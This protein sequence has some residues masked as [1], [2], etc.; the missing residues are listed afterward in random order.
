M[1]GKLVFQ[2]FQLN[3][4]GQKLYYNLMAA[5]L[6][7]FRVWVVTWEGNVP[8]WTQSDFSGK[9]FETGTCLMDNLWLLYRQ[10]APQ[11]VEF[12]INYISNLQYQDEKYEKWEFNFSIYTVRIF[13]PYNCPW[14]SWTKWLGWEV[15]EIILNK[16]KDS[17]DLPDHYCNQN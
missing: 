15:L 2:Q 10:T 4:S 7:V 3:K 16:Q 12:S 1:N 8:S 9:Y 17:W 11:I 6:Y 13:F 5:S 14:D